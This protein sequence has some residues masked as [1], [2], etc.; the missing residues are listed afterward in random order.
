M[1]RLL[2]KTALDILGDAGAALVPGALRDLQEYAVML[3]QTGCVTEA[4]RGSMTFRDASNEG[5]AVGQ[6]WYRF[7]PEDLRGHL[8]EAVTRGLQGHIT[9]YWASYT[10]AAG[11]VSQWDLRF[12]PLQDA[13]DAVTSVIVVSRKLT[14][15]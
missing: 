7:W 11:E 10:D 13:A 5:L 14:T 4:S 6:L 12:S 3:D 8:Q 2:D 9:Q 15:H 1:Y